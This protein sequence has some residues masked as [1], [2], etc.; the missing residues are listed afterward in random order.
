ME[1]VDCSFEETKD[2]NIQTSG[3]YRRDE[4][5]NKSSRKKGCY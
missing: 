5:L 1:L 3:M 4:S 2:L